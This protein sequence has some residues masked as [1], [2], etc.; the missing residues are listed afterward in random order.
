[1]TLLDNQIVED[2]IRAE[3]LKAAAPHSGVS[4]DALFKELRRLRTLKIR[5]SIK[6]AAPPDWFHEGVAALSG[7]SLTIGEFLARIDRR[8]AD[9]RE[10]ND[11]G[12]WLRAAGR[13]TRR[14][15]GRVVFKI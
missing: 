1:M 5:P 7:Q 2:M 13:K 12:I 6:T 3:H 11:V 9:K 14:S 8:S 15:G 4:V 10:R